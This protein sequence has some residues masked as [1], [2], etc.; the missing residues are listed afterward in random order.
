MTH[1]YRKILEDSCGWNKKLWADALQY[2]LTFCQGR[3][4]KV[5]E[6]GAGHLSSISP[7]FQALGYDVTCSYYLESGRE[8]ILGGNLSVV[9]NKNKLP[10][11]HLKALD[12]WNIK[13][14]SYDIIALKSIL[15][16]ICRDDDYA[17]LSKLIATLYKALKPGGILITLDNQAN[18][19]AKLMRRFFGAGANGWTYIDKAKFSKILHP[20]KFSQKG[21]GLL[22]FAKFGTV[23]GGEVVN[24]ALY[25]LDKAL[26]KTFNFQNNAVLATVIFKDK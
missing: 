15:G 23:G 10:M 21:F 14:K 7:A 6:I 3:N 4:K 25:K 8:T 18:F 11:P 20:Y 26:G 13:E 9:C 12:A 22:N 2:T 17:E 16:G 5:L 1:A 24:N 19:C